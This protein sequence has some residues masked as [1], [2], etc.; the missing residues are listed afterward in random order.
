MPQLTD[1]CFAHGGGL[2]SIAAALALFRERV[3]AV[4]EIE[5]VPLAAA[6]GRILAADVRAASSLPP[7]FNSAVDG[8]AVRHGDLAVTGESR[9][10]VVGRLQAGDAATRPLGPGEAA[11]IFTGAPMPPG[12]D[13]VF[14]QEDVAVDGNVVVLPP[15]LKP[16]AN[17]RPA[18]EEVSA[19][20]L[21]LPA[22]RRLR[23]QDL[24]LAAGTGH[25]GLPVRRRLAAAVFSTGNEVVEPGAARGPAQVYDTNRLLIAGLLGRLG[26][27]VTDLGILPDDP[28]VLEA[29]LPAAAAGH[30][31]VVTSGGVS[32]GEADHVKDAVARSGRLDVWRFAIKPGRP[33]ALGTIGGT[34]FVGLPGNP[35]AVHVT[36]TQIV[37]GLL[38]ALAGEAWTPPRTMPVVAGFEYRKRAARTE[39]VRVHLGPPGPDG[40][41]RVEK[42]AREGA[43][44]V[45]SLTEA[46]GFVILGEEVTR[47]VPGDRVGF[48]PFS[49]LD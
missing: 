24:A 33:L 26:V 10:A 46:D 38:A 30:D 47:V 7:F 15:G 39:F 8:Y 43:G 22:G 27:A 13:T 14:M 42:F 34:A 6:S 3:A 28:A 21:V 2:M 18:G 5:T 44:I 9:F 45:S 41:A 12:A 40:L 4:T 36:M 37:R 17:A 11:R 49:A 32:T 31:I 19:G 23:P 48:L 1:D 16:G 25:A 35:V 29:R 20:A